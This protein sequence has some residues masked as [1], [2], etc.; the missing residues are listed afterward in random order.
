ML[1]L[2]RR[3]SHDNSHDVRAYIPDLSKIS[4]NPEHAIPDETRTHDVYTFSRPPMYCVSDPGRTGI[5]DQ[6]HG[7]KQ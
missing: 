5:L 4:Q 3:L 2:I 1:T 7:R 6:R